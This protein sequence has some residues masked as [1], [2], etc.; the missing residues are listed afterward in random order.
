MP[1]VTGPPPVWCVPRRWL[2]YMVI[3]THENI[4]VH[5]SNPVTLRVI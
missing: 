1:Q 5:V 2:A 4:K 3:A